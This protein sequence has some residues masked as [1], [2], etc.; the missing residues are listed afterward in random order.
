MSK[1]LM[2]I[3]LSVSLILVN[4]SGVVYGA[5]SQSGMYAM[6]HC[7]TI[8]NTPYTVFLG[9]P[10]VGRNPITTYPYTIPKNQAFDMYVVVGGMSSLPLEVQFVAE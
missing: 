2:V 9:N 7:P 4:I 5:E 6:V 8:S 1:K 3:M 10:E